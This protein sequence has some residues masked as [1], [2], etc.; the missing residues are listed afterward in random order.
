MTTFYI[1]REG[2]IFSSVT[3]DD[4]EPHSQENYAFGIISEHPAVAEKNRRNEDWVDGGINACAR[5]LSEQGLDTCEFDWEF[6][7]SADSLKRYLPFQSDELAFEVIRNN[8]N[9]LDYDTLIG[10]EDS[11][12]EGA[13]LFRDALVEYRHELNH[14]QQVA[15]YTTGEL[16]EV[17]PAL[18]CVFRL[19]RDRYDVG[20]DIRWAL[21]HSKWSW[22][23]G[24]LIED[25]DEAA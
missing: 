14:L 5:Y 23:N 13:I 20:S 6:V 11:I 7:G 18:D 4:G 3:Y 10:H 21:E 9:G 1:T 12:L 16:S 15:S 19:S 24:E 8:R 17:Q 25:K 2:S 22:T